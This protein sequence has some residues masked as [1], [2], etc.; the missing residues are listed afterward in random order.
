MSDTPQLTIAIPTLDR[1]ELLHRA[2]DSA[3]RQTVPVHVIVADQGGTAEVA[4]V[5][6]RYND[7]PHVE[8]VSTVKCTC[9]W[10]NWQAAMLAAETPFVAWLQDDDIVARGY[11]AR[12]CASFARFPQAL[13]WQA[14]VYCA[15]DEK[16]AAWWGGCGPWVPMS[17]LDG[18][19]AQWPGQVLVPCAYLSSW[20]LSP[21]VAFRR[22]P[23]LDNALEYMPPDADLLSERLILASMGAQGPFVADPVIA[24]YWIHHG[25]NESYSQH[26][27]Q[28]RQMSVMI[29]RLDDLMDQVE[30]QDSFKQ[31]CLMMNP[32]QVMG[33][34]DGFACDRSR[35]ADALRRVMAESLS[36]RVAAVPPP[37]GAARDS[38]P[39]V[40]SSELLWTQ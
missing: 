22:G 32:L 35:H 11:A 38:G 3:L 27:D 30:W 25:H 23:E 31:W 20:S 24:G 2:I 10:E 16:V 21:G 5:M 4:Q 9:L 14:R 36:G 37:P 40:G 1:A 8:H 33:F 6:R 12:I 29:G 18:D 28:D 7:H 19:V 15:I 17:I 13:H 39:G 34:L 26:K